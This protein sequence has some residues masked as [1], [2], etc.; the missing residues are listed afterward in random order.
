MKKSRITQTRKAGKNHAVHTIVGGDSHRH[1]RTPCEQCPWRVDQTGQFPP[2]AFLH[3]ANTAYDCSMH[4]FACHMSGTAHPQTC[5]GFLLNG[6]ADNLMVRIKRIDTRTMSD[7]GHKLHPTY[8]AMAVANGVSPSHPQLAPCQP[9]AKEKGWRYH[10]RGL[11][12][13]LKA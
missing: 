4:A 12:G 3:S 1:R 11:R 7:G 6:S 8:K 5:A 2:S 9:E 10:H 13:V